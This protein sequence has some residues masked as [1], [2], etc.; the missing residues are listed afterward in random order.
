MDAIVADFHRLYRDSRAW[1]HTYWLG[2]QTLKGPLDLWVYQELVHR[3]RPAL[4]VETGT[5]AGGSALYLATVCDLLGSGEIVTIDIEEM[6]R[7]RHPR[8]TYL[9]GSSTDPAIVA[10]V[11]ERAASQPGRQAGRQAGSKQR[12]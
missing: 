11:R 8:I 12:W 3:I 5:H 2:V 6:E 7:P 9:Q 10:T 1:Q 4:I